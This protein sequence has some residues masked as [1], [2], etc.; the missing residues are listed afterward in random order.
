MTVSVLVSF[1]NHEG[2]VR[3]V[4]EAVLGQDYADFEA[5]FVDDASTD[6][7][8]AVLQSTLDEW[9]NRARCRIKCLRN[10][11]NLGIVGTFNRLMEESTGE[12]CITQCGDDLAHPDR[13]S[14]IVQHWTE[15]LTAHPDV[16]AAVSRCDL[17]DEDFRLV[18]AYAPDPNLPRTL[19]RSGAEVYDRHLSMHGAALAYS[20]KLWTMFGP[21][22]PAGKFEDELM[23]FRIVLAGSMLIIR[24]SLFDYRCAG[25]ASTRFRTS[26][27]DMEKVAV[28]Q[29]QSYLQMQRDLE[30]VR[31]RL[32]Q[33]RAAKY[34]AD[35]ARD[36]RA[37]QLL[38]DLLTKRGA[39][40]REAARAWRQA[41]KTDRSLRRLF[42]FTLPRPL[43]ALI[44][45]LRGTWCNLRRGT[46]LRR[47]VAVL[48]RE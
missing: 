27:A 20:R 35:L 14:K 25:G 30:S 15:A 12:I 46:R 40:K 4:A 44:A 32:P 28:K 34:E 6:E 9:K 1:H 39:L 11:R 3:R 29:V 22:D 41:A 23:W 8:W 18:R 26:I 5:V 47:L 2:L 37:Q 31:F 10:E 21:L 16:V 33:A 45:W 43:P 19:V 7:S 24:E 48:E 17:V 13:V 36:L 42:A 38:V